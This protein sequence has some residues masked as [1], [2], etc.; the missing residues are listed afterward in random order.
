MTDGRSGCVEEHRDNAGGGV[1]GGGRHFVVQ[2]S[3]FPDVVV[4]A[5][6]YV[7]MFER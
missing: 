3:V 7:E 4:F 6:M 2:I 5:Q 1:S